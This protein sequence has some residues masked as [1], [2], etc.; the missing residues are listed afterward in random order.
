MRAQAKAQA[1]APTAVDTQ[2]IEQKVTPN[3]DKS[4]SKMKEKSNIK[5]LPSRIIQQ[6]PQR[7]CTA[8]RY[9]ISPLCCTPKYQ[10]TTEAAKC[11]RNHCKP[12]SRT[13][14]KNG[15]R[16]KFTSPRGDHNQNL[17][18]PRSILFGTAPRTNQI[19]ETS[20]NWYKNIFHDK[21]T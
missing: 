11:Q 3:S 9:Y 7:H 13:R 2:T 15:H 18:S 14:S 5:R 8:P 19:S 12:K 10:A 17:C 1:N 16:G 6:S 21:L 4:P 20:Q